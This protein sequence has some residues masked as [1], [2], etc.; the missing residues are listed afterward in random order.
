[1][2]IWLD[3][4]RSVATDC[5]ST[6]LVKYVSVSDMMHLLAA[7]RTMLAAAAAAFLN[8]RSVDVL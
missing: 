4:W 7:F 6:G 2:Y 1:M 8:V 3:Q 5:C